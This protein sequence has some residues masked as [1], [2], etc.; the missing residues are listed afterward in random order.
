MNGEPSEWRTFGMRGLN[1][2][3][4]NILVSMFFLLCI[5]ACEQQRLTYEALEDVTVS[6]ERSIQCQRRTTM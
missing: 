5:F 3:S 4:S 2:R 6:L 1:Q